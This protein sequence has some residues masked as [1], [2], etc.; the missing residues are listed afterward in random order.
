MVDLNRIYWMHCRIIGYKIAITYPCM[1]ADHIFVK[2]LSSGKWMNEPPK[3]MNAKALLCREH[4]HHI[5]Y[6][7]KIS[8]ILLTIKWQSS[9]LT[10]RS[11]MYLSK[12]VRSFSYV[13]RH[14]ISFIFYTIVGIYLGQ[15]PSK[16]ISIVIITHNCNLFDY[17]CLY[18]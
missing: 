10:V 15:M 11:L 13:C 1:F 2:I 14:K 3:W 7:V 6:C 5:T 4:K 9:I 8:E 16:Q 18:F 12:N 17:F